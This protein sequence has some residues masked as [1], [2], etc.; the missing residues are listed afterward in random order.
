MCSYCIYIQNE[1]L[2]EVFLSV[3]MSDSEKPPK[4]LVIVYLYTM[5][6]MNENLLGN[7]ISNSEKMLICHEKKDF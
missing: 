1:Q 6:T 5:F 7:R 2:F 4:K 3:R